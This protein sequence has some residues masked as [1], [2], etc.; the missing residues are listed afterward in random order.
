MVSDMNSDNIIL[1]DHCA[2][3]LVFVRMRNKMLDHVRHSRKLLQIRHPQVSYA[4]SLCSRQ[5]WVPE[6]RR[7]PS[8]F[9][10]LT[11]TEQLVL[12]PR[13]GYWRRGPSLD[14]EET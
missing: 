7:V 11:H 6:K 5:S 10:F 13:D 1:V 14:V 2:L 3:E 12:V 9:F 4:L 8:S